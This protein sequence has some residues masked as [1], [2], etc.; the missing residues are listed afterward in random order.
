MSAVQGKTRENVDF[1]KKT[2][3]FEGEVVAIN[4]TKDKLEKLLNTEIENDIEYAT[5]ET[6]DD[7]EIKRAQIVFWL[8]DVDGAGYRPARFFVKDLDKMNTIKPEEVGTKV[9]K[10]QYINNI[11]VTT[12]ADTEANLPD[13][14][15][16]RPYRV[17]KVGEEELYAFVIAWL[18]KLERRG[19]DASLSFNFKK[20]VSGDVKELSDLMGG[21][22]Q[23]TITS[24]VTVR[25]VKKEGEEDKFYEQIYNRYFIPGSY[26]KS[27]R[28]KALDSEFIQKAKNTEGKKR[29]ALQKFVL[30]VTN[31]QYGIRNDFYTLGTLED[32]DPSKD[33][34]ASGKVLA[35]DDTTY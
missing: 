35:E 4:P 21:D 31:S 16:E 27:V 1:S 10:K 34:I 6:V 25:K 32:W 3:F 19:E 22:Y 23:T 7:K 11:G 2:G 20:L 26:M 8:K 13:W 14:F 24:L 9:P 30:N 18:S 15:K 5:V 17:A 29:N 28:L 33:P 12:W